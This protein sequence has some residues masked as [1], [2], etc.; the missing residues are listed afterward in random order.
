VSTRLKAVMGAVRTVDWVRTAAGTV[1]VA[2]GGAAIVGG[3]AL[4]P[5]VTILH[6]QDP[7][8]GV[9]GDGAYLAT[10]A[11]G[12]IGL[13]PAYL[14]NGR[15]GPMRAL[16]AGA[17]FLVTYWAFFDTWRIV[18]YIEGTDAA[19]ILGSPVLGPGALV[20][21]I[22]GIILLLSALSVPSAAA[23]PLSSTA[24]LRLALGAALLATG[25]IHLQ[26]APHHLEVSELFGL[27]FIA[28]AVSQLGL[29][30]LVLVRG[31]RLLYFA[32]IVDCCIFFLLYVYAVFHG[33]PFPAHAD[34]G[35]KLGAGE[36]VTLS[37][38]LSKVF[39]VIAIML[40]VLLLPGRRSQRRLLAATA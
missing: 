13:W 28:A 36:V 21:G 20:A 15:S 8:S 1:G 2:I 22:G 31:H 39:E 14:L 16:T 5:W 30:A 34:S 18:T 29:A 12:A 38:A 6:G 9:T 35:L 10:A 4:L 27:G 23:E 37:G 26:Q 40:A 19:S 7:I 11:V 32:V 24:W 3:A 17:G 33:L 25:G